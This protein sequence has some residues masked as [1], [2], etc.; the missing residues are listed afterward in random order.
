MF[1]RVEPRELMMHWVYLFFDEEA[2]DT[3]DEDVRN[4][5]AERGLV[6]KEQFKTK[7]DDRE[8][9]ILSF[10]GCYLGRH[11]EFISAIQRKAMEWQ[12]LAWE[13]P[14]MLREGGNREARGRVE[15]MS[16][17][18]LTAV[19]NELVEKYWQRSSFANDEDGSL[20]V[21]LDPSVVQDSFLQLDL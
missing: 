10:G 11:L 5:I 21:S 17:D 9:E 14:K 20:R 18:R 16:D 8:N 19:V 12:A 6:P 2:P 7:I 13:I 15:S 1:I 3:E 4:Y